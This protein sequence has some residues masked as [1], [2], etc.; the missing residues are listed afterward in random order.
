M[1]EPLQIGSVVR[2]AKVFDFKNWRES[3]SNGVIVDLDALLPT[4][5]R[6]FNLLA[7]RE[8]DYL[9]VGG[10][11]LLQY[12]EGRNTEDIDLI[13]AVSDM[14][15]LPEIEIVS[16][17]DDFAHGRFGILK[18]D[19]L[20]TRNLLFRTV[21]EQFAT[22]HRFMEREIPCATVE[23]LIVLKLYAL[24]ALYR[25]GNFAR[26]GLYENDIAT[27]MQAYRPIMSPLLDELDTHLSTT[28]MLAVR[29]VV[30]DIERR[31]SRF[32]SGQT[33]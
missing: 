8:T 13:M 12:V 9:L 22:T 24:P 7:E 31:I 19:L 2:N 5:S 6:F 1:K 16:Q 32:E 21:A 28:D 14:R 10:I 33:G 11:A 26:V 4:V 17:D 20:L 23:G 15:R 27:L 29:A 18:V 25:M 30:S 3:T